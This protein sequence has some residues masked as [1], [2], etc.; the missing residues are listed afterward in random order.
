ME[1]ALVGA[2]GAGWL[3]A[4]AAT[5]SIPGIAADHLKA[6]VLEE[7][8]R[9]DINALCAFQSPEN[10]DNTVL[11]ITVTRERACFH[12]RHWTLGRPTAFASTMT[13]MH[14]P[15]RPA[16]LHPVQ[17]GLTVRSPFPYVGSAAT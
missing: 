17:L 1:K 11:A 14:G 6:P 7:D 3:L 10:S 8:R 15:M 2:L 4:D 9:T 5:S 13:V 16:G 12:P